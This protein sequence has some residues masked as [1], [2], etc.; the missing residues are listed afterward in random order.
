MKKR[1]TGLLVAGVAVFALSGCGGGGG[2]DNGIIATPP[3][4]LITLFLHD[5]AGLSWADI[6]Y[7]CDSMLNWDYTLPNGE[8]TFYEYDS[9]EFDFTGLDGNFIND[10]L[11]DDIVRITDDR[12]L[13]VK[14]IKYE[15]ISYGPD[16]THPDGS[17]FYD[18]DDQCIFHFE[19][20]Y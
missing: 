20:L 1:I 18:A 10:P 15:C 17:F 2:G 13:G 3:A 11:V 19:G 12:D 8:F 16:H 7:R 14:D 4:E 9:C 6:P 5:E